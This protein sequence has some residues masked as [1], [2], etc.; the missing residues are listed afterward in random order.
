[1]INSARAHICEINTYYLC[2]SMY[3][4]IDM[5]RLILYIPI[6]IYLDEAQPTIQYAMRK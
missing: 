1:M 3:L 2:I 4:C 6:S 5:R